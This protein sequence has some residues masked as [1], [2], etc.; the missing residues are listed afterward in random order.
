MTQLILSR[1]EQQELQSFDDLVR[2]NWDLVVTSDT[3]EIAGEL[4]RQGTARLKKLDEL[5]TDKTRPLD[6]LKKDWIAFFDQLKMRPEKF[7]FSL[8]RKIETYL[9]SEADK[10]RIADE[11]AQKKANK[12]AEKLK[13]TADFIDQ[14]GD[15]QTAI[16]LRTAA[17][18]VLQDVK[19]VE[20][21]KTKGISTRTNW[22]FRIVA[23]NLIPREYLV[24][25]EKKLG[26][27][28]RTE[29]GGVSIAGVEFY[30]EEVLAVRI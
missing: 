22:K 14:S 3:I 24:P 20:V 4:L 25:D 18:N 12:E 19:E 11:E 10:K 28:A 17:D 23:E 2:K 9:K 1:D 8:K 21:V 6:K 29:K 16:E 13:A 30:S 7:T 27:I 15:I 5:R 26:E